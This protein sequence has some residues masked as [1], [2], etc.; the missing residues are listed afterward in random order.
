MNEAVSFLYPNGFDTEEFT[1]RAI[2][3]PTNI[4]CDEWNKV[5]QSLNP[6]NP[7]TM[8]SSNELDEFDDPHG[9]IDSMLNNDSLEYYN[10]PGI[11]V[12]QLILKVGDICFLL[13]T[14]SKKDKLS[15]N[16]RIRIEKISR[17]RIVISTIEDNPKLH[18]IPRIKF[19]ISHHFGYTLLR[20]QFPMTLAYAMTK[21]FIM[22]N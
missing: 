2:L 14:I 22:V 18:S 5:I 3:A 13:R 21:I 12:H 19:K 15:K 4:Q 1:N 7:K 10:K 8:L 20:T 16:T 6:N 9:I 11:P 17:Y